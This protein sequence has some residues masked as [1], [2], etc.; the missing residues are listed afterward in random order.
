MILE[1]GY[2]DGVFDDDCDER[3]LW[4]C[5]CNDDDVNAD[6]DNADVWLL[7]CCM[8]VWWQSILWSER[9]RCLTTMMMY[10][11]MYGAVYQNDDDDV[12]WLW[13]CM[14][15]WGEWCT[16]NWWWWW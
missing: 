6:E 10:V 11:C 5:M 13:W 2:Y 16:V 12:W 3:R 15:M 1:C 14:E 7:W 4:W 8:Y 9:W